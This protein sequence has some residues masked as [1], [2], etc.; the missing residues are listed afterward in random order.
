VPNVYIVAVQVLPKAPEDGADDCGGANVAMLGTAGGHAV[1]EQGWT[2]NAET[3]VDGYTV[4][5]FYSDARQGENGMCLIK[6]GNVA[7]YKDS[8]LKA[9]IYGPR[10]ADDD[11]SVSPVAMAID[12][13][14]PHRIQLWDS[15]GHNGPTAELVVN[16]NALSVQTLPDPESYCDGAAVVPTVYRE[17]I[18]QARKRL[19]KAGWVP[20]RAADLPRQDPASD[21][22][23]D[24]VIEAQGCAGTGLGFC[25][26][27]Y[28]KGEHLTL[29]VGTI[30]DEHRVTSLDV[31]CAATAADKRR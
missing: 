20:V 26:F 2:V 14:L 23:A 15:V 12:A 19:L 30:G 24:G 7:I 13:G 11:D 3:L 18:E 16:G 4:I 25:D 10:V 27:A 31:T 29:S 28:R 21:L 8:T 1:A 17:N 6:N 22:V 5:S 9:L